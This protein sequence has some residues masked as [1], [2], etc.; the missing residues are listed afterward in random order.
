MLIAFLLLDLSHD[1]PPECQTESSLH[2]MVYPS[3]PETDKPR[4]SQE[5]EINFLQKLHE[6]PRELRVELHSDH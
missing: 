2:S 5:I 1:D 6:V 4:L 3:A